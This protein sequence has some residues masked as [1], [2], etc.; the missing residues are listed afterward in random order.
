MRHWRLREPVAIELNAA[1]DNPLVVADA[2]IGG[3]AGGEM[4]HNGNFDMAALVL[5]FVVLGQA[6]AQA[7][8][9]EEDRS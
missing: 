4:L 6:L 5:R 7:A 2:G 8:F 3:D 9:L 1:A